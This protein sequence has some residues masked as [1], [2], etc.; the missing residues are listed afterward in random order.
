MRECVHV[1][2]VCVCVCVWGGGGGGDVCVC[3]VYGDAVHTATSRAGINSAVRPSLS[4]LSWTLLLITGSCSNSCSRNILIKLVEIS[5]A[6]SAHRL[7]CDHARLQVGHPSQSVTK[8][9]LQT[10]DVLDDLLLDL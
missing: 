1:V 5:S 4:M 10:H 7:R 2:C 3:V 8:L 6:G 9:L